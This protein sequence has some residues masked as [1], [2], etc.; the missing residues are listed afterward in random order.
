MTSKV[1]PPLLNSANCPPHVLLIEKMEQFTAIRPAP[2]INLVVL[3]HKTEAHERFAQLA[4]HGLVGYYEIYRPP[5]RRQTRLANLNHLRQELR[6]RFN[7]LRGEECPVLN[8]LMSFAK[9]YTTVASGKNLLT[10]HYCN[11]TAQKTMRPHIDGKVKIRGLADY[12]DRG[13][14]IIEQTD[15]KPDERR[16]ITLQL[17]AKEGEYTASRQ[18]LEGNLRSRLMLCP[19]GFYMF[20]GGQTDN[21]LL[22]AAVPLFMLSREQNNRP[23]RPSWRFDSF[24]PSP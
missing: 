24:K 9:V 4:R 3:P 22:H 21:P 17:Y 12:S 19:P 5:A 6:T 14:L 8:D 2:E 23:W 16:A 18:A 13:M 15:L 1:Q 10:R 7:S 20:K 11:S